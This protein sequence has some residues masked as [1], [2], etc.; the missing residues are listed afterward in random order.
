MINNRK[1]DKDTA[2]NLSIIVPDNWTEG[3]DTEPVRHASS[4]NQIRT[5]N[6]FLLKLSYNTA[7]HQKFI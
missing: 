2:H 6:L 3:I 7:K 1:E 5:R 4:L